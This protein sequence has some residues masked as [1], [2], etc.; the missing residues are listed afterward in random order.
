M[1]VDEQG[2]LH[3]ESCM[4]LAALREMGRSYNTE[5]A[6][7][8]RIALF[9]T[10]CSSSGLAW[11]EI[12]FLQLARFLR[13]LVDEPLPPR[14]PRGSLTPKFRREKSANAVLTGVCEFLRFSARNEWVDPRLVAQ[15]S[16][17]KY[18]QWMPPGTEAGEDNQF[19]T[20]RARLLKLPEPV[21]DAVEYLTPDEADQLFQVAAHARDKFLIALLGC[22]GERIGEA[23]GLRR[24]DMHLLADSR[25]LGCRVE[26]AHIHVRR[27]ANNANGALAKSRFARVIPVTQ[28][29]A[30]LY[31]DYQFE[32]DG[33]PEAADCDMVFVN[34]F[35]APLGRP[36]RYGTAK[37]LF[38]RLAKKTQLIARPH[39]LRHGAATAWIRAG[40][41]PDVVQELMGQISPA[42]LT[43][44]LH[45]SEKEK[46]EAV[47]MVAAKGR[48]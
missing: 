34:L 46:R 30:G 25:T 38:D 45:R 16:E 1:V 40:V 37:E 48:S 31:A 8:G 5:K 32:R 24:Q 27:R 19:R 15:L 21:E 11:K 26:G 6:Y 14:S 20:I 12:K 44:Y 28:N 4:F 23:L 9:L 42:S 35:H 3:H 10:W 41:A 2:Q 7:A 33:V 36:M 39:M 47:E 13:W 29:L 17:P 43:P 18:L 22:T